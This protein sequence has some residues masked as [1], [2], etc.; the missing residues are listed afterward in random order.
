MDGHETRLLNF[1]DTSGGLDVREL[2]IGERGRGAGH[3]WNGRRWGGG[4]VEERR[5]GGPSELGLEQ[6]RGQAGRSDFP[7]CTH[8]VRACVYSRRAGL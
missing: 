3:L 5:K 1:Y 2:M 6:G 8:G 4:V 7:S